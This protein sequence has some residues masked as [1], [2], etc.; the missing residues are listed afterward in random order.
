MKYIEIKLMIPE[1]TKAITMT[2]IIDKT[3]TFHMATR[4]IET[5]ELFPGNRIFIESEEEA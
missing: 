5:D 4:G 3:N 1:T 2:A